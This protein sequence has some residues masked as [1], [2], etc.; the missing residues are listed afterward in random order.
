MIENTE[1]DTYVD[2][3][4]IE[5]NKI[6]KDKIVVRLTNNKISGYINIDIDDK[7]IKII[8]NILEYS[9]DFFDVCKKIVLE[10]INDN[11]I[12]SNDLPNIL[13]LLKDIYILLRKMKSLKL[14][15]KQSVLYSGELL[16]LIL[17]VLVDERIINSGNSIDENV[18]F[19]NQIDKLIDTSIQLMLLPMTSGCSNNIKTIFSCWK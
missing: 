17:N 10:I 15:G 3:D 16:K 9:P 5:L 19:L 11:K 1:I 13:L 8:H 18:L 14:S 7:L 12:D 2:A 4:N 6:F